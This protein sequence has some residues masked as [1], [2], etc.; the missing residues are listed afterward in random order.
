MKE[1]LPGFENATLDK[2]ADELYIREGVRVVCDK[3]LNGYDIIAHT[4]FNDVIGYGSYPS[5]LRYLIKV[6][7]EMQ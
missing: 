5:D 1:N 2:I 7:M 3:T 6:D 4:K